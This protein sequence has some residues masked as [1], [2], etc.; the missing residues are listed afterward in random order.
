RTISGPGAGQGVIVAVTSGFQNRGYTLA[1]KS[2]GKGN[3]TNTHRLWTCSKFSSDCPS[4]VIYN[5]KLFFIRDD[6][7]ASCLDIKTGEPHWQE[8]LFSANVKVSPVAGDGKV[9]F[10]N[11]QGNC[12]IVR[13]ANKHEV[14]GVSEWHEERRNS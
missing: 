13:A 2:G 1:L 7:I 12:A 5:G 9:Y 4:P 8:R 14:L 3:I 11:G 6:G 10:L